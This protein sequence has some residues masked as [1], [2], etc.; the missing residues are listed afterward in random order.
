MIFL[1]HKIGSKGQRLWGSTPTATRVARKR[2]T[3]REGVFFFLVAGVGFEPHDLRVMSPTSYQAALPRDMKL[4]GIRRGNCSTPP[5]SHRKM[6]PEAGIE[7]V[8]E[9]ISRDFKSRASANSA[10]PAYRLPCCHIIISRKSR[11]VNPFLRFFLFSVRPLL[12]PAQNYGIL[13]KILCFQY[14]LFVSEY[15]SPRIT[16]LMFFSARMRNTN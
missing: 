7:P 12:T 3:H 13:Y 10:I 11:F 5:L 6:V 4:I 16:I 15:A 14:M 1:R 2:K 8:R 9:K